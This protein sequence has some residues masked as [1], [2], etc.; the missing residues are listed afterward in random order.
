MLLQKQSIWKGLYTHK[1]D[2]IIRIF[3]IIINPTPIIKNFLLF[4]LV[5]IFLTNLTIQTLKIVLSAIILRVVLLTIDNCV[6]FFL[7]HVSF[8][9]ENTKRA[10]TTL[11]RF[12]PNV[13]F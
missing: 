5:L 10:R 11:E 13:L 1:C 9:D 4:A 8:S 3:V 7:C 2:N 6:G 12:L